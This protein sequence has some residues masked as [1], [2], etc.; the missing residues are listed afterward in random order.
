MLCGPLFKSFNKFKGILIHPS[1]L[2]ILGVQQLVLERSPLQEFNHSKEIQKFEIMDI[3]EELK[4]AIEDLEVD[5]N[6]NKDL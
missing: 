3:S 6:E 2:S 4:N 1:P 5:K